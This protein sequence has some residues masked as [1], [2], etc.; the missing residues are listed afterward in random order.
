[1]ALKVSRTRNPD[2]IRGIGKYSRSKMYHKRGLWAIKAKKGRAFSSH[3]AK[4][5]TPTPAKKPSKCYPSEDIKKPLLNKRKPQP[6]KLRSSITP[7]TVL[8]LLAGRFMGKRVVFLKQLPSG[9][10]LVTGN[11]T[12]GL[13]HQTAAG[14]G[15]GGC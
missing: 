7:S 6:T 2:L 1:M 10:L 13:L 11:L 12:Q 5:K 14:S 4:P 9:L 3:E 8:I 15:R